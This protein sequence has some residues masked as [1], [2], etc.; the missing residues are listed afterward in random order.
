[1]HETLKPYGSDNSVIVGELHSFVGS[2]TEPF[3]LSDNLN[4]YFQGYISDKSLSINASK[5]FNGKIDSRVTELNAQN[6][7]ISNSLEQIKTFKVQHLDNI[8]ASMRTNEYYGDVYTY[9]KNVDA[10]NHNLEI[11]NQQVDNFN[12]SR[13][14]YNQEVDSF[15]QLLSSFYPSRQKIQENNSNL[16]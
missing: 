8:K 4:S 13:D 11:Y 7:G 5:S 14:K 12:S 10:F 15:N 2:E 16:P 3:S 1:M 6:T 9:N